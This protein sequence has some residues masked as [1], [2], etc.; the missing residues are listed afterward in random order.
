MSTEYYKLA[1]PIT[2]VKR[3]ELDNGSIEIDIWV[4]GKCNGRFTHLDDI[5][6]IE[7]IKMLRD[8]Y[9]NLV[10]QTLWGGRERGCLVYEYAPD[11]KDDDCL[12]SECGDIVT[13][14]KVRAKAGAGK[15][16]NSEADSEE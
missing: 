16:D 4:N 5:D 10:M 14:A 9:A 15:V 8:E 6:A 3:T 12:I 2:K 1:E 11:L 7:I 13:V